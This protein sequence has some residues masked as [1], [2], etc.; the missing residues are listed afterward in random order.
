MKGGKQVQHQGGDG[1]S[2]SLGQ[3]GEH[4]V[5]GEGAGDVNVAE[6]RLQVR[7]AAAHQAGQAVRLEAVA[8]VQDEQGAVARQASDQGVDQLEARR[9]RG[10]E[11]MQLFGV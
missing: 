8:A 4:L 2:R 3:Q 1:G 6:G 10:Q 9:T 11:Q 7:C 5:A